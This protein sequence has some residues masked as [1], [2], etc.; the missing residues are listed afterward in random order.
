MNGPCVRS[1]HLWSLTVCQAAA[2]ELTQVFRALFPQDADWV[3]YSAAERVCAGAPGAGTAAERPSDPPG[4]RAL[5]AWPGGEAGGGG[6]GPWA[7]RPGQQLSASHPRPS[8]G[9]F[10]SPGGQPAP[11]GPPASQTKPQSLDP[12]ADLGDLSA[13]LQGNVQV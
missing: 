12:F 3:R 11:A 9:P 2:Q 8:A 6:T 4:S 7:H 13:S 10:F 1:R 5:L